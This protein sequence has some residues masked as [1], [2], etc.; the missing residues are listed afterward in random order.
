MVGNQVCGGPHSFYVCGSGSAYC[1]AL[2]NPFQSVSTSD[3]SDL[4]TSDSSS[5]DD[6][7]SPPP[8][9]DL[10]A[11][12]L[13]LF[14]EIDVNGAE[15]PANLCWDNG[16]TRC[17]VT[18]SYAK[19]N[20]L[21]SQNIVF[22][23]DV[24]GNRGD[25]QQGC[26]YLF[27]LVL[28]DGS[29]RKLWGYGVENIMEPPDPVDLSL[30]KKIFPHLPKN[31]FFPAPM[32]QI[33]ILIGNNFLGLHP[34]GGQGRDAVGNLRAYQSLFGHG[35]VV[36]GTHPDIKPGKC[37][38]S[39][40][41]MHLA[42]AFKCEVIP[43]LLPGFWEGDC[44]GVLPPKRCGK[45][46]RCMECSDP[47]LIRSRKEQDELDML[48]KGVKLVNGQLQVSYPFI[49]DPHCLPNNR[50]AVIRMAEKQEKRLIKSG[51]LDT[52][53]KEFQKYLDRGAAVKLSAQELDEYKG[54]VNYIS[55][56][57]VIQDSVTTP[58]R[59][60][61]NS[62]LKNGTFSLNECLARGPNSL[63]SMLEI[64]L[65]FRCHE[66]GMVFDLTKAYNA[67]KTGPVEKNL[68]RFVW[69]F[70]PEDSLGYCEQYPYNDNCFKRKS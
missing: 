49:R 10:H 40:S 20:G 8:F 60:V 59:I 67:L 61:T 51:F 58:L 50:H 68:R 9:P 62:S 15:H 25:P 65:R 1:G 36:A 52:Y 24:V 37:T 23:L 54:P 16:S 19:E 4:S 48:Q 13:L 70:S 42:R 56:H 43:E 5:D 28:T 11:E 55:H 3:S 30:V 53:N 47:S 26:Y 45:C 44:L 57:G 33:D 64:S 46:L 18:H 21:K 17:L 22:R 66:E 69:R 41:A 14:Q 31:V 12:T 7:S 2:R 38:L 34:S 39:P 35:W 32:K 29:T 27:E 6:L 63:N